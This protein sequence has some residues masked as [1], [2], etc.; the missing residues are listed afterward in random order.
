LFVPRLFQGAGRHDAPDRYGCLYLAEQ[1]GSA[2]A[3][4]LAPF[5]NTGDL[6][7]SLL[8]RSGRRLGL[9]ELELAEGSAVVDLD[10]P[11]VLSAEG[12]HPS[13]VA[14]GQRRRSQAYA[15]ALF[16]R[17]PEAAGLRWW[18]SLESSWLNVTLFDRAIGAVSVCGVRALTADEDV[19]QEAALH[20]G[21]A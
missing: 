7:D 6:D 8:V 4:I 19:V 5:R 16:D 12:L 14:T 13:T 15:V 18:S 2:V 11:T 20:L 3:E 17:H 21:L 9:A 1:P 10:E